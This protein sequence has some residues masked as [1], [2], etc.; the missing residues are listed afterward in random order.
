MANLIALQKSL[1]IRFKDKS[2]LK[3]A[4]IH[5]SYTNENPSTAPI[6]NERLEFL[7]DAILG[8][9]IAENLFRFL[10]NA[11]EGELTRL[12]ATLVCRSTLY[13]I[14]KKI[15]LNRHL[16]LGKGE[17]ASGGR[18]KSTNLAGALEAIVAAV[19]LD[20][21]FDVTID[22]VLNLFDEHLKEIAT[23]GV[24]IDYKSKL[25]QLTQSSYQE[26]PN[27]RITQ[28]S[29]SSHEPEFTAEVSI[30]KS[31]LGIGYGKSKKIA[32]AEAARSALE[33]LE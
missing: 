21:G 32:E 10:P 6:H 16:Y 26:T 33:Q 13:Y 3:Q 9:T 15:G 5:S 23:K 22:F 7:G 24:G 1:N 31:I 28:V 20:S 19:F 12:R 29:G 2:L 14:A 4:L 25:Q 27:Y 30:G 11:S 17:E 8:M 18:N